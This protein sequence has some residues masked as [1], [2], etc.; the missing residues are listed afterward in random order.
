ML[1]DLDITGWKLISYSA[2]DYVLSTDIRTGRSSP[3]SRPARTEGRL[4]E[5]IEQ[6]EFRMLVLG[7]GA[8]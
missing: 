6:N 2:Q 1:N 3:P 4:C 7:Y 5:M 8:S